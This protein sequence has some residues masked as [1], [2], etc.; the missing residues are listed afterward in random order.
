MTGIGDVDLKKSKIDMTV[1]VQPFQTIDKVISSIPLIGRVLTGKKKALITSYYSIKGDL[2]KP[3]V[4]ATPVKSIG[5]GIF[6]IFENLFSLPAEI[7]KA[8]PSKS[9]NY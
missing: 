5:N 7:F 3:V 6:G 1:G 4:R 9:S 8:E 2:E